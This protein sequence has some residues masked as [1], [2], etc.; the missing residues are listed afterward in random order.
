MSCSGTIGKIAIVPDGIEKGIINQALLTL[1]P[2]NNLNNIF[3]KL[4]MQSENFQDSLNKYSKGAAIKNIASVKVLKNIDIP[5]PSIE[6]QKHIVSILD[7]AFEAIDQAKANAEQ[8]LKNVKELFQSKLQAIFD[9]GKLKIENGEWEEKKLGE[10]V[11]YSKK[12]RGMVIK[13]PIPFI[14]MALV[15]LNEKYITKNEYREI[16]SS[17]TFVKKGIY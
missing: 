14:P 3:L 4:W 7:R 16:V 1:S 5:L 2:K 15:P 10:V 13:K 11:N 9:N 6:E 17:G 8:N 12:T